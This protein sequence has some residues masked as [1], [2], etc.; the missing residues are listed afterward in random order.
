MLQGQGKIQVALPNH[1]INEA[2]ILAPDPKNDLGLIQIVPKEKAADA[3]DAVG[4]LVNVRQLRPGLLA[5]QVSENDNHHLHRPT[6]FRP[7]GRKSI[8]WAL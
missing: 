6:S 2:K 5:D 3:T 1:E 8:A 4:D 7:S